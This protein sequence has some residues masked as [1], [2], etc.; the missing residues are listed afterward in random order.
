MRKI[1]LGTTELTLIDQ[2]IV[3]GASLVTGIIVARTLGVDA[4]GTFTLG[5]L[6]VLLHITI[7]HCLQ[8]RS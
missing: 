1:K 6:G 2:V 7:M 4:L 5:M 8:R 3:S